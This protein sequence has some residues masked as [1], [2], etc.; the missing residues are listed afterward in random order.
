MDAQNSV[1]HS[2]LDGHRGV[3]HHRASR[4]AERTDLREQPKVAQTEIFVQ[5]DRDIGR[6]PGAHEEPIDVAQRQSRVGN[7]EPSRLDGELR[8]GATVDL[9]DLRHA[10]PG[11]SRR[12][13]SCGHRGA[14]AV[15]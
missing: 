3:L 15:F 8:G 14:S 1:D 7:R 9:A 11:N 12:P 13:L 6:C 4:R 10:E 2:C 5:S